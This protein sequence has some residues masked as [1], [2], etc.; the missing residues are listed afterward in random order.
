MDCWTL[1]RGP[2]CTSFTANS[3]SESMAQQSPRRFVTS[4]RIQQ[5]GKWVILKHIS[6]SYIY[7]LVV[8]Q[9]S[10]SYAANLYPWWRL[11][12]Q[13]RAHY[14]KHMITKLNIGSNHSPFYLRSMPNHEDC[15]KS[16]IKKVCISNPQAY[17]V[18][19]PS[20]ILDSRLSA[21]KQASSPVSKKCTNIGHWEMAWWRSA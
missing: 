20:T 1:Q 9:C 18:S 19:W 2:N 21:C 5:L 11:L 7:Y 3:A 8:W 4:T 6:K 17:V 10:R 12:H 16:I 13:T 14:I 15:L